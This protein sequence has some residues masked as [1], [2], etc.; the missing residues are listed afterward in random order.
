MQAVLLNP[1]NSLIFMFYWGLKSV[2]C[3]NLR[4]AILQKHGSRRLAIEHGTGIYHKAAPLLYY[5]RDCPS[6]SAFGAATRPALRAGRKTRRR[7]GLSCQAR[8]L[9]PRFRQISAG[10][11]NL[12]SPPQMLPYR[13]SSSRRAS[14]SLYHRGTRSRKPS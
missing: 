9:P 4:G 13:Q 8:T 3:A 5:S 10:G 1:A 7:R 11:G 14:A 12:R 2:Y 6:G